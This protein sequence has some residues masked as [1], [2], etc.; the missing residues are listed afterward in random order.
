MIDR[1]LRLTIFRVACVQA[2]VIV[3]SLG[4]AIAGLTDVQ[5]SLPGYFWVMT[6]AVA[7]ALYLLFIDKLGRE[8]G[9]ND[10]GL[11]FYNNLLA[12]PFMFGS[13]VFS[14]EITR[15]LDYPR[16]HD[17]IFQVPPLASNQP[18]LRTAPAPAR[19]AH[20]LAPLPLS[21]SWQMMACFCLAPSV[22]HRC[23][24]AGV[25][26]RVG[27]A[28][29]PPQ[30][31]HLHVHSRQLPPHHFD[32]GDHQGPGDKRPRDDSIRRLPIQRPQYGLTASSP[33]AP[34][35]PST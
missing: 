16:L 15:V 21:Q 31:P 25:F 5:F 8:S 32:H 12:F 7:T 22:I 34:H 23:A 29:I 27:D 35:T 28:G 24:P 1:V 6:C 10:F 30:L 14:G 17:P 11:L 3:M 19:H 2:A 13:L 20:G 26:H 9:L 33:H 4:A 18:H